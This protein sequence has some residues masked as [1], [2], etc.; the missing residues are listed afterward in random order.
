MRYWWHWGAR[1]YVP[2]WFCGLWECRK[3]IWHVILNSCLLRYHPLQKLVF[4]WFNEVAF[5]SL[6]RQQFISLLHTLCA[7]SIIC[8]SLM[9]CMMVMFSSL[10][11]VNV[12]LASSAYILVLA[13]HL[14]LFFINSL[15][16]LHRQ[17][18]FCMRSWTQWTLPAL[19]GIYFVYWSSAGRLMVTSHLSLM[20]FACSLSHFYA[21]QHI[22]YSAY[23]PRRFCPSVTRVYCVKTAELIIEILSHSDRPIILVFRHQGRCVNLTA[24]PPTGASNTRG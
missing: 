18:R 9:L 23:M 1:E 21:W 10:V 2:S 5:R 12:S 16:S 22:C 7:A 17:Q 11:I 4:A 3:L 19:S 8:T 13:T 20:L 14:L 24:S 6:V 15:F